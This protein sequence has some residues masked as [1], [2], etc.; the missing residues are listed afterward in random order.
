MKHDQCSK[1][2]KKK[3][4]IVLETVSARQMLTKMMVG[5]VRKQRYSFNEMEFEV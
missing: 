2:K 1:K 3:R 5:L 4:R